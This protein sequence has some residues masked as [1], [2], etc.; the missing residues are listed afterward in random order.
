MATIEITMFERIWKELIRF[1]FRLLYFELAWTYDPVSWIVS[2]G[3]WREWQR[4][5]L[6]FVAHGDVL[7]LGHGPGHM[8]AAL[9][10][11]GSR[12]VGLDISPYMSRLAKSRSSAPLVRAEVQALPFAPACFDTVLSTFPTEYIVNPNTLASVHRV[13]KPDG[14]LVIVP[15]GHLTGHGVINRLIDWLFRVTGQRHPHDTGA[16]AVPELPDESASLRHLVAAAGFEVT[17]SQI[18]LAGSQ[19]VV[20]TAIRTSS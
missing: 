11:A 14:R 4:A 1:S 8:L 18:A 3:R 5:A 12:A 16:S 10:A 6:P 13:L 19:V 15:E 9:A 7:E 17:V 20:V 2:R